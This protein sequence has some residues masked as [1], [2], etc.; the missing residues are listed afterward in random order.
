MLKSGVFHYMDYMLLWI[1]EKNFFL[2]QSIRE[3]FG[4]TSDF[5][6]VVNNRAH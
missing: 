3:I 6:Q 1:I 2:L 5:F 4:K